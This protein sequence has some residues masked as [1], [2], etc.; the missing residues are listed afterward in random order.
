[1][2]WSLLICWEFLGCLTSWLHNNKIIKVG[3][4]NPILV[5]ILFKFLCVKWKNIPILLS[6]FSL[7]FSLWV[8]E[9][10]GVWPSCP[11]QEIGYNFQKMYQYIPQPTPPP[12]PPLTKYDMIF[13]KSVSNFIIFYLEWMIHLL[14]R[15]AIIIFGQFAISSPVFE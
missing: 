10:L 11:L 3:P 4:H 5:E 2:L 8:G 12:P 6:R 15:V 14:K 1:M 13:R 9:C 7:N